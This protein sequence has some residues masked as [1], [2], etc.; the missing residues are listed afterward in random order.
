MDG[1]GCLTAGLGCVHPGAKKSHPQSRASPLGNPGSSLPQLCLENVTSLCWDKHCVRPTTQPRPF[2]QMLTGVLPRA[3]HSIHC[4]SGDTH[5]T[6]TQHQAV[7]SVFA[8]WSFT[9]PRSSD[10]VLVYTQG[11]WNQK[12]WDTRILLF[13]WALKT[14]FFSSMISWNR[15]KSILPLQKWTLIIKTQ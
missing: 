7:W 2:L 15:D 9:S 8:H 4:D 14:E 10:L 6:P 5:R 1:Q 3:L 13:L 12:I 11:N